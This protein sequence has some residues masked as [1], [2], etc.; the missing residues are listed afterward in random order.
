MHLLSDSW[1][2]EFRMKDGKEYSDEKQNG[3]QR[4]FLAI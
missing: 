4:Y 1:D 3:H 2:Q